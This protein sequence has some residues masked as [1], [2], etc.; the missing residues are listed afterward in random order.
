MAV[1]LYVYEYI[2]FSRA[3]GFGLFVACG[4]CADYGFTNVFS[5]IISLVADIR[6][7]RTINYYLT[8]PIS[9]YLVFISII[10][11]SFI[12]LLAVVLILL[13]VAKL[14]LQ[15]RFDL[16]QFS[17]IKEF[18]IFLSAYIFY[19]T[20]ALLYASMIKSID[21]LNNV[22]FRVREILFWSGCY[23]FTWQRLYQ[24][25]HVLAYLDL[26]NPFVYPCEG[27]RMA[28]MRAESALPFWTCCVALLLFGALA[29]Y[30]GTRRLMRQLDCI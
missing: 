8:L 13:P 5:R 15:D 23:F 16:T 1:L 2:G 26:L 19:G 20:L 6:G 10:I 24:A 29:T 11:A 14:V 7:L 27:M 22:Y 4:E 28:I 18:F 17:F 12:K 3:A 21:S 25:N 9:H 30:V